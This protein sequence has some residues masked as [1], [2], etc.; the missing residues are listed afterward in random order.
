MYLKIYLELYALKVVCTTTPTNRNLNIGSEH[1]FLRAMRAQFLREGMSRLMIPEPSQPTLTGTI[2]R[3]MILPLEEIE[4]REFTDPEYD[5]LEN[6]A[7]YI[8]YR[9]RDEFPT[10]SFETSDDP[11]LSWVN[12]LSD[13]GLSLPSAQL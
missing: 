6:V 4:L 11:S 3:P 13:G 12:L 8:C 10:S 5:G 9:L 2:L 7:G 1:T